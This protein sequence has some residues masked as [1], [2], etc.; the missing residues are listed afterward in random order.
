MSNKTS[1]NFPLQNRQAYSIFPALKQ[2]LLSAND[3]YVYSVFSNS[4]LMNIKQQVHYM[5]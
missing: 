5:Y 3:S 1:I 4:Y 2:E